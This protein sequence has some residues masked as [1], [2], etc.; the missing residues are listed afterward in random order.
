MLGV[1]GPTY[2]P[3]SSKRGRRPETITVEPVGPEE[4]LS[5]GR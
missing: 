3:A 2:L 4:E 1:P 5:F